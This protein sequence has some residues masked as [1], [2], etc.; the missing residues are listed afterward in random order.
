M[1]LFNKILN[2][3]AN[4]VNISIISQQF[5]KFDEETNFLDLG[6][7]LHKKSKVDLGPL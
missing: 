1:N 7:L 3:E 4:K 6:W 5:D 2:Y